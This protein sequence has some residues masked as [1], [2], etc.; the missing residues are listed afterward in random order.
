MDTLTYSAI[1]ILVFFAGIFLFGYLETP[2][3]AFSRGISKLKNNQ[4]LRI[5]KKGRT[6][7]IPSG[8]KNSP[9]NRNNLDF[10]VFVHEH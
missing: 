9:K 3:K 10:A 8:N 1:L 2:R 4:V 7:T 6:L 5:N